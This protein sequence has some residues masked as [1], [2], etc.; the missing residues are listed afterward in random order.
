MR[1]RMGLSLGMALLGISG[2]AG[3]APAHKTLVLYLGGG[4]KLEM[5]LV[6]AGKF[7]M[8][9]PANEAERSAN[10]QQHPVTLT[11]PFWMG[12]CEITQEQYEKVMG[13]NPSKVKGA[14][15]PVEMISW[16]EAQEFC[17]KV[18]VLT[19]REVRLPTEAE[20]EYACRA[21]T[22][23]PFSTG[24]TISAEQA[25]YDGGSVYAG[26]KKGPAQGKPVP[27]GSYPPN[28]WGLCDLHGN[29]WEWCQDYMDLYPKE[30]VTDPL[31]PGGNQ[32][33]LRG[34]A[35]NLDP[36]SC[37]AAVRNALPPDA[38]YDDLGF[39]VAVTGP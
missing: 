10:E 27:A 14:R 36:G 23:T 37:R 8:G 16:L 30:A 6:P 22:A 1:W 4:V 25:N 3:E 21:G 18:S 29:V 17:K 7:L 39:R 24:A 34:G 5:V 12:K 32:R 38:R 20:W 35:F 28:A 15:N 19:K 31:P 2:L 11:K 26:G 13:A 9:S 33:V